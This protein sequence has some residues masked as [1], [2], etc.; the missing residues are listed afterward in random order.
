M[1]QCPELYTVRELQNWSTSGE[2]KPGMWV[3]TRPLSM[4]G[5]IKRLSLAWGAFRG[6]YDVLK[7]EWNELK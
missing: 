2:V 6:E 1:N 4:G 7:W 5:F 3:P